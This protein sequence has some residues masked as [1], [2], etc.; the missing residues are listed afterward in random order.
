VE[1][2]RF[3]Q[4]DRAGFALLRGM[5]CLDRYSTSDTFKHNGEV[6]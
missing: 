3:A 1:T 6:G 4:G 5:T 2:L